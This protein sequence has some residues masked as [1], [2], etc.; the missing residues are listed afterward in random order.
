MSNIPARYQP[1]PVDLDQ[2][3]EWLR[4]SLG[5]FTEPVTQNPYLDVTLQW[6]VT[7]ANAAYQRQKTRDQGQ[8]TFG[9]F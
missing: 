9:P 6:D 5:F 3:G 7:L 1:E 8:C 4:W 2:V